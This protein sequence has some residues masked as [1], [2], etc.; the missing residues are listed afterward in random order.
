MK[1]QVVARNT[2]KETE[3]KEMSPLQRKKMVQYY[4]S[5]L[6]REHHAKARTPLSFMVS[7]W[8][9]HLGILKDVIKTLKEE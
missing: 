5:S 4:E 3:F 6:L 1:N 8:K 2:D 7:T 9:E